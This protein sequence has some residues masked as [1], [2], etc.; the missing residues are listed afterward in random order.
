MGT[1][2]LKRIHPITLL[3]PIPGS[4]FPR[5]GSSIRPGAAVAPCPHGC[6][7]QLCH[8]YSGWQLPVC[9]P[10]SLQALE[11]HT[12]L[13]GQSLGDGLECKQPAGGRQASLVWR[14]CPPTPV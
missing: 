12:G 14:P 3:C 2:F 11:Q 9:W 8:E 6:R 7:W 10:A 13:P 4:S 5:Q 1:A